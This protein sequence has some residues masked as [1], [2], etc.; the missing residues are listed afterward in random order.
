MINFALTV[1]VLTLI[2][3]LVGAFA[4]SRLPSL[5]WQLAGLLIL[6]V[7]LPDRKSVV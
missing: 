1:G 3:G 6:A 4:I 2:A 5:S 7:T